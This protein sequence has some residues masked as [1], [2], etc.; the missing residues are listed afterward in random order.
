MFV[1]SL[2]D[3]RTEEM[4]KLKVRL[5][6]KQKASDEVLYVRIRPENK[7]LITRMADDLNISASELV[8]RIIDEIRKQNDLKY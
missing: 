6:V 8:D 2:A 1:R 5:P 3:R 7:D 4:P